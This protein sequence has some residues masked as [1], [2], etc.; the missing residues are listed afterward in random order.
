[1]ALSASDLI[2]DTKRHLG[3]MQREPMNK[4]ATPAPTGATSLQFLYD[5]GPLTTGSYVSIGLELFYVWSVD[6]ATKTATVEAAQL[7]SK[8]SAHD[9]GEIATVNP[10]FPDFAI[11][12]ALNDE[13]AE[14]SS[15]LHGLYATKT[16]ELTGQAVRS[17]YDLA[18]VTSVQDILDVRWQGYNRSS[19]EWP[20]IG[21]YRLARMVSSAEFP[22]GSTLYLPDGVPSGRKIRVR[23]KSA[24]T[25]L[26]SLTSTL[27]SAGMPASMAD[28]P[29]MGAAVRL[30]APREIKR[31]FTEAQG[32]PRRAAEVPAGAVVGS[33]RGVMALRQQRIEAEAAR[34][35]QDSPPAQDMPMSASWW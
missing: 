19:G 22:S 20:V 4:L 5:L 14:L 13:L 33:M 28:I 21:N 12:R 10:K 3:S 7:G 27:D 11:F 6:P 24:F 32:E 25:P 2:Q 8:T 16:V 31:N 30:V 35:L 34:L 26:A 17:G 1:M 9:Q 15:P 18:G 29:P 23:Y